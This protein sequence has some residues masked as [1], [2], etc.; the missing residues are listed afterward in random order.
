MQLQE[1]INDNY[2]NSQFWFEDEVQD[3]WHLDRVMNTLDI[4]EYLDGNMLY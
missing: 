1:Y 3:S 2:D 4:K